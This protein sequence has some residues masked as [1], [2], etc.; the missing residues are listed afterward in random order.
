MKGK[1]F[2]GALLKRFAGEVEFANGN[3]N[4]HSNDVHELQPPRVIK[5][6]TLDQIPVKIRLE[7]EP[8]L[9]SINVSLSATTYC[10]CITLCITD[11]G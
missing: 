8:H 2:K 11:R 3:N 7:L 6:F 1:G 4:I 10:Y 9:H 5:F